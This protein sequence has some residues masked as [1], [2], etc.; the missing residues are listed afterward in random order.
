MAKFEVGDKVR[1]INAPM[2]ADHKYPLDN[3]GRGVG[4]ELG[5]E[6]IV[7]DIIPGRYPVYFGDGGGVFENALELVTRTPNK[8]KK[9]ESYTIKEGVHKGKSRVIQKVDTDGSVWVKIG[10]RMV[11]F[12]RPEV[13][14]IEKK[15]SPINMGAVSGTLGENEILGHDNI[16]NTIEKAAA[17]NIPVLLVG[18]TGTGKTTI[19]KHVAEKN[20]KS[21]MRF[22]LTGETTVDDFVGKFIL[23]DGE[24][25]WQ[26]GILLQ[27]MKNGDWL[28][29]DEINVALPEILFVLHSLL[30][31]DKYV[32]VASNDGKVVRPHD[33]FRFFATMN[34]VDEYAG[35]K[36]LNKAF[37]SRFG[38][39]LSVPYPNPIT[40][41]QIVAGRAGVDTSVSAPMVDVATKLR[42][43]KATEDIFYTCSTRDLIQW[44][45]LTKEL[46]P[47]DAFEAAILN[48]AEND[49]PKVTQAYKDVYKAFDD[50]KKAGYKLSLELLKEQQDWFD[51]EKQRL[52]EEQK[53]IEKAVKARI[54]E[55]L[56]G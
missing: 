28:I 42:A 9:G 51:A 12:E 32:V 48:K 1:C 22:N 41:V 50:A 8:F 2:P 19:V 17:A 55:K 46:N 54:L 37:K 24:T 35:T 25:V 43:L 53:D 56:E 4:W 47:Q 5:R 31:D 6:F 15:E 40:E 21:W 14:I 26:D 33:D 45:K 52:E 11:Q 20:E 16:L 18:E 7:K 36:D 23:K 44:A 49:G 3:E 30:D 13:K 29:V 10:G 34:P 38:V 27:A 39:I